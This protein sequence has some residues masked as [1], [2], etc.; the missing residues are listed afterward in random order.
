MRRNVFVLACLLAA[1][2]LGAAF[3]GQAAE[4][5]PKKLT[6]VWHSKAGSAGDLMMR[7]IGKFLENKFKVTVVVE[8][9]TGASG[10]NAWGSVARAKPD[11][12]I[13]L[14]VSST[15]MASPLQNQMNV[16]YTKL[17]P[18]AMLFLDAICIYAS[19]DS[20]YKDLKDFIDDAKKKPGEL[21]LTGGTAGNT[22]FVS[23]RQL[24]AEAGV[25]VSVVPF[26]G[27]SEGVVSVM[28]GHITAGCGEYSEVAGGIESGKLK[29]LALFNSVPGVNIPTVADFGYKTTVE[30]FRGI[31]VTKNTPQPLKD[32]IY[33]ALKEMMDDPGFK[34]FY[35]QNTLVPSFKDAAGFLKV[36]E[37]QTAELKESL[38][39]LQ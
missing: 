11:G 33:A 37:R 21:S 7:A 8:N 26:D 22:E 38:K 25:D 15:F 27:G 1:L 6:L 5:P 10:A 20:P 19:A 4:W 18:L 13:L 29:V 17:D 32:A 23:A 16:D 31:V 3:S 34:A 30:K 35:T 39:A 12:S 14:G 24:M 9:R 36:M 28:G 2:T